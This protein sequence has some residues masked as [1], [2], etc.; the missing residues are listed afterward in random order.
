MKHYI[1]FFVAGLISSTEL[2]AQCLGNVLFNENFGGSIVQPFTGT[3]LP[4]GVTTY[5]FDS[6]GTIDDGEYGIR[7]S[8]ADVNTGGPIF[9][10]WHVGFDHSGGHM[11]IVNAD[12]TA[13]KFYE[14]RVNN[15]CSGSRLYFSAWIANLLKAGS[16]DPLDP[17]VRF[18]I[19]SAVTGN[20]LA[21]Y[22]TPLIPRFSTFTWTRYGFDFSL[23][24]GEND[25]ILRIFNNQPGG[26]GN[27]LCLDDIEFTL[28]G[29]AMNPVLS[30]TYQ[31]SNEACNGSNISFA[32]N[33][34][35]GFYQN[36]AYQ[37]Q[38][39]SD[40]SIWYDITG[41]Q[42]TSLNFINVQTTHSGFYRLLAAEA[43][44][45]NSVNCRA[46]SPVIELKVYVTPN[47]SIEGNKNVCERDTLKLTSS[48][49]ALNYSWR[50]NGNPIG[51]DSSII[52]PVAALNRSG[53]Y[54]LNIIT[55]G[56]CTA[57]AT[58]QVTV[59]S[60]ALLKQIPVYE[61]LCDGAVL[62]VN[63][64]T[65]TATQYFWN[66]S[67]TSPQ[68]I[69]NKA[70]TYIL[71]SSDGVCKRVDTLFVETKNTPVLPALGDVTICFR[72]SAL[73]NAAVP[74]AEQYLWSNGSNTSAIIVKT[75][76][77]YTIEATNICGSDIDDVIV[78]VTECSEEVFVPKAF[79]PNGNRL[80]EELKAK[81]YFRLDDYEFRI[82]D[83]WGNEVFLT[84]DISRGWDGMYRSIKSEPGAYSW[85][86]KYTRNGITFRKKG[87]ALL[88]R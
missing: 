63:A 7:R 16:P 33:V 54:Q 18:E 55:R 46:V 45:I 43:V 53:N 39:S 75:A 69:I 86:M 17:I 85:K 77:V 74:E 80:N 67:I 21:T 50:F 40:G 23:P 76:G 29:P 13:G 20:V 11:M 79:T 27:D 10:N 56:G 15:L 61:L 5:R 8:S 41:S 4:P 6:T 73:I 38:F 9:P 25:V 52:F 37:W 22:T 81:A 24:S 71:M 60:N 88:I 70:G 83:R 2:H 65:P 51:T 57:S 64:A 31:N 14:T 35:S 3:R 32:G 34:A 78:N 44:N 87:T 84:K 47:L 62:Q 66:D 1:L 36:P 59:Q 68:R 72:D 42:T 28:C 30:G 48:D 82:Y 26:Q 58:A 49:S 19:A 12:F